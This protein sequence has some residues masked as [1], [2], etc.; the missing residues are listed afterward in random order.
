MTLYDALKKADEVREYFERMRLA[1]SVF[2]ALE[3]ATDLKLSP[4]EVLSGELPNCLKNYKV[5]TSRPKS[6]AVLAICKLEESE[7]DK[8]MSVYI[9]FNFRRIALCQRG[10]KH[11]FGKI[12]KTLYLSKVE[13]AK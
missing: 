7:H 5:T 13:K 8:I 10:L 6:G 2:D 3:D 1:V 11:V 9:V 4:Y 12:P